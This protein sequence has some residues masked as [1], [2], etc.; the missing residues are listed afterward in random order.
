MTRPEWFNLNGEWDYAILPKDDSAPEAFKGRILV[1]YAVESALSGVQKALS[2]D[3]RLWYRRAFPRPD[4]KNHSRALLHFG[5]VDYECNVWVNG[6]HVG[7]H[8]GGYL[9]FTF[10][11]TDAVIKD[12]NELLV[13]V[14]DPTDTGLQQRGK[15][16]LQPKGIWYTAVSGIWQTV[17]L[18]V[19]PEVSIESLKLTPDLD[20]QLLTVEVKIRGTVEG[21]RVEAEVFSGGEKVSS[22]G[23]QAGA[24]IYVWVT[25]YSAGSGYPSRPHPVFRC[26]G[27]LQP[28]R[29]SVFYPV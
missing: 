9:P 24:L 13:A 2:S 19:V 16:V 10:D 12:E 20:S 7:A 26:A 4:I 11:I 17:W 21:L 14:W 6:T 1:P 22:G 27:C 18:E 5:A 29:Q 23:G 25:S 8:R 15:Q 3:Q 28:W